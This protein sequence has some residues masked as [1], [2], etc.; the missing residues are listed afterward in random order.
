MWPTSI[1]RETAFEYARFCPSIEAKV[2][3]TQAIIGNEIKAGF[4]FKRCTT[5]GYPGWKMLK[6][7][8]ARPLLNYIAGAGGAELH[9]HAILPW[10]THASLHLAYH[11]ELKLIFNQKMN[12]SSVIA[13]SPWLAPD[14][15][16]NVNSQLFSAHI[17]ERTFHCDFEANTRL[18]RQS[19]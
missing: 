9:M 3:L 4:R 17:R 2:R 15:L 18:C 1:M 16:S 19:A 11:Q 7:A 5:M 10:F 6:N 8:D 14:H 13:P 12:F